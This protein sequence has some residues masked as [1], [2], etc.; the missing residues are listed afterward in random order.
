MRHPF[1]QPSSKSTNNVPYVVLAVVIGVILLMMVAFSQRES[2][3]IDSDNCLQNKLPPAQAVVL[4]DPS[5]SLS[6]VQQGSVV[7]RLVETVE[8]SMPERTEIRV[9]TMARAGRREAAPELRVCVP[10]N[11]DDIGVLE[12]LWNN[13]SIAEREYTEGFRLPLRRRLNALL[14]VPSDSVSPIVEAVQTAVVDAFRP[15]GASVPRT[16]LVVSDMVQNSSDLSFF[17]EPPDFGTFVRN[18]D[19]GTLRVDL[20]GVR[21]AVFLLARRGIAGRL[22]AGQLKTFWEEYFIDQNASADAG[23]RW[24]EVEG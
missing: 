2:V 23:P 24:I 16:V 1:E 11:P 20:S 7:S 4:L 17:R 22:Q 12:S 6:V 18:P 9:Y 10:P 8:E 15:R 3:Q 14:D 13:R 5:D 21:L 19:Y